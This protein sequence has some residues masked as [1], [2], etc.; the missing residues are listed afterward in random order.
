VGVYR[1]MGGG[2]QIRDGQ[3]FLPESVKEAMAKRTNWGK[4]LTPAALPQPGHPPQ[5]QVRPPDW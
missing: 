5:Y 2:W 3:D 4:L 1:A